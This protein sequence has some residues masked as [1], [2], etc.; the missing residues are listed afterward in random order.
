MW[1]RLLHPPL[2]TRPTR[3]STRRV[4]RE[5]DRAALLRR[6]PQRCGSEVRILHPPLSSF[7]SCS[8]TTEDA[9]Y[10]AIAQA[11]RALACHARGRGCKSHWWR[12]RR[13]CD[14]GSVTQPVECRTEN[15]VVEVRVL[16]EPLASR[17][18]PVVQ[19]PR[20]P[21]CQGGGR[22]FDSRSALSR[23][24]SHGRVRRRGGSSNRQSGR[25][26]NGTVRVRIPLTAFMLGA[27]PNIAAVAQLAEQSPR[28]RQRVGSTPTCGLFAE[29]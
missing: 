11:A 3:A 22:G 19:R 17:D 1:V 8:L 15:P 4:G 9:T 6:H 23:S 7:E 27:R 28:K 29:R 20:T 18:A 24:R 10:A 5:V 13:A 16:P 26:P 25:L 21:P 12:F 2:K 14:E